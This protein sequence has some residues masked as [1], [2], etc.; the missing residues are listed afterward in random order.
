MYATIADKNSE[1]N[2][3]NINNSLSVVAIAWVKPTLNIER[4]WLI[5]VLSY[6]FLFCDHMDTGSRKQSFNLFF[7]NI[8]VRLSYF[9]RTDRVK[10]AQSKYIYVICQ[11]EGPY[12]E[13][14]CQ[15]S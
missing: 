6:I 5:H 7:K 2:P 14:Q 1:E 12:W 11:P 9:S 3:S 15:R 4:G 13:K 8:D 10:E